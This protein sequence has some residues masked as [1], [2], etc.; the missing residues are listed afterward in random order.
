M[1]PSTQAATAGKKARRRRNRLVRGVF[2]ERIGTV[3]DKTTWSA[4]VLAKNLLDG[5]PVLTVSKA[6]TDSDKGES[7]RETDGKRRRKKN[8][9]LTDREHKLG[10]KIL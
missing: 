3:T 7:S 9:G 10:A 4:T 8:E 2:L 5:D 1:H 6:P